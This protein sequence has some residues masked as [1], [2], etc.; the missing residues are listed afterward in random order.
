MHAFRL[1]WRSVVIVATALALATPAT[2]QNPAQPAA[3]GLL[4]KSESA[5]PAPL[6]GNKTEGVKRI[7]EILDWLAKYDR[8]GRNPANKVGFRLPESEVNEYL[9]YALRT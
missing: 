1:E 8:D 2:S 6:P 5:F 9:A 4:P 3:A 7:L